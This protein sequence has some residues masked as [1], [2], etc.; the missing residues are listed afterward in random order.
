LRPIEAASPAPTRAAWVAPHR[1]LVD[2]L[3]LKTPHEAPLVERGVGILGSLWNKVNRKFVI[4]SVHD[5]SVVV[6][7]AST[8]AL[9][10]WALYRITKSLT[11]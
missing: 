11:D 2:P 10:I 6:L 1:H 4:C 7:F 5:G 9:A 3:H 8:I